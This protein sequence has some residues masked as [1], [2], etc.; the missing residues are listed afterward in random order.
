MQCL[1][2]MERKLMKL[3]P[4][5]LTVS[6]TKQRDLELLQLYV[7]L[8]FVSETRDASRIALESVDIMHRFGIDM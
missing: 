7:T 6:K 8:Y 3:M 4:K 1:G 5:A 2:P